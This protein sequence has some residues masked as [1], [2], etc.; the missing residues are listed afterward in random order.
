MLDNASPSLANTTHMSCHWAGCSAPAFS[1]LEGLLVHITNG[2][3]GS[4]P[5]GGASYVCRWNG[6]S[7]AGLDGAEALFMHVASEH[8]GHKPS[9]SEPLLE[10]KW[11][12]C[13]AGKF[14]DAEVLYT[15]I[16]N[17]HVGRKSTGNLCLECHWEG[18]SVKRTKRDHITSHIRVH[19]P[20][21]PYKCDLCSK[22]FKRPQD[23][24][25]HEKTHSDPNGSSPPVM[26][27]IDFS[28]YTG[29]LGSTNQH[30]QLYTPAHSNISPTV[31]SLS[32][33]DCQVPLD[34]VNGLGHQRRNSP[35]T[36]L[37]ASPLHG[38]LP[39]INDN[40]FNNK[41][42]V[43]A[44]EEFHQTVKKSRT[45]GT[46]Q[47]LDCLAHAIGLQEKHSS[48]SAQPSSTNHCSKSSSSS[49]SSSAESPL[50]KS[51]IPSRPATGAAHHCN[52]IRLPGVQEVMRQHHQD[53][54]P[55]PLPSAHS[56]PISRTTVRSP[57]PAECSN[58]PPPLSVGSSWSTDHQPFSLYPSYSR[59]FSFT[60]STSLSTNASL[61][62]PY[63]HKQSPLLRTLTHSFKALSSIDR[64]AMD[65]YEM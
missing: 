52:S 17:D 3:I 19:V 34:G 7:A 16:T 40:G 36:P 54:L 30:P 38:Y 28:Y 35:Y 10:C 63:A 13:N 31:G 64:Y 58:T 61:K 44:I 23:L 11:R 24:K 33:A 50:L 27:I 39:Q 18:C 37:N 53:D 14:A 15:H 22:S 59:P 9:S 57:S 41:R 65:D 46:S 32:P 5:P 47:G 6:C 43:D 45:S 55:P 2:H 25:K 12:G 8:F 20:L 29:L 62:G 1:D 51:P 26:P 4:A 21:K 49:S 56:M 48:S 60:R 42:G